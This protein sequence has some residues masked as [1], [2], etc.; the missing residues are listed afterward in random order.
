MLQYVPCPMPQDSFYMCPNGHVKI[1]FRHPAKLLQEIF[2]KIKLRKFLQ[3]CQT[4]EKI[5][6]STPEVTGCHIKIV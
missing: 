4:Q 3:K 1:Y 5:V 2:L 6:I